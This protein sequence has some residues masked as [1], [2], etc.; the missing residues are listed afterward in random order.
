MA[1]ELRATFGSDLGE[2]TL[3]PGTGC[4]CQLTLDGELIWDRPRDGGFPDI[5]S[6]K[7]RVRDV[8]FPDRALGHIDRDQHDK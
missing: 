5:K 4:I 1:Q 3:N 8:A 2:V 6:L 7:R